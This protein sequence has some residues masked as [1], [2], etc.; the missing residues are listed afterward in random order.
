MVAKKIFKCSGCGTTDVTLFTA[1]QL[2][3]KYRDV[4]CSGCRKKDS[5]RRT[6]TPRGF[7]LNRLHSI[8]TKRKDLKVAITIDDL[9]ALW[10]SQ[11]GL[12][13]ITGLPMT[14]GYP[15][16][17]NAGHRN[18][19]ASIDRLHNDGDYTPDN[20]RLICM[21]ANYMRGDQTDSELY[22]WCRAITEAVL[23]NAEKKNKAR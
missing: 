14:W 12:C 18:L 6:S 19:N 23:N 8:G 15:E 22:F 4:R 11:N 9:M 2:S 20:I 5:Q 21:R 13:A 16:N 3:G 17:D 10:K 7:L 1:R